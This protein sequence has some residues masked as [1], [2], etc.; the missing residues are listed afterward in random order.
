MRRLSLLLIALF[1]IAF[2]MWAD[3]NP[4]G[5]WQATFDTPQ[6]SVTNTFALS[7]DGGKVAGT[8]NN[9]RTGELKIADGKLDGDKITFT[10]NS[11]FGTL[12]FSGTISGDEMK[13]TLNVGDGQ[14]TVDMV[15]KRQQA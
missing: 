4:A 10:T 3:E 14:F 9:P 6:G 12:T 11:E 2:T 1:L 13:L 5:T 8:L 15:A 7:L